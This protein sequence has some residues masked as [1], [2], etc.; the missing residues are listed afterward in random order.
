MSRFHP[1]RTS[2]ALRTATITLAAT[3]LTGCATHNYAFAKLAGEPAGSRISTLVD[4]LSQSRSDRDDESL[5]DLTFIPLDL[6]VFSD[7]DGDGDPDGHIEADFESYLPVF[8]IRERRDLTLWRRSQALRTPRGDRDDAQRA[9]D[10]ENPLSVALQLDRRSGVHRV[11][12]GV[13]N[14]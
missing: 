1:N 14:Q 9:Q 4:D 10:F 12:V 13:I 5:Y 2:R 6:Q 3:M 8:W 7:E 11:R